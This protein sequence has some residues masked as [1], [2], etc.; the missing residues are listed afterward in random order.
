MLEGPTSDAR[1][2]AVMVIRKAVPTKPIRY[3]V[4]THALRSQADRAQSPRITGHHA[5]SEQAVL[6]AAWAG[7]DLS[8][9]T[10]RHISAGDVETVGAGKVLTDGS[11]TI[12]CIT[13]ISGANAATLIT[14]RRN[15]SYWATAQSAGRR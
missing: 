14:C 6:R 8:S 11:R 15:G 13:W 12:S 1:S 5:R 7:R 4:N 2:V 10:H 3:V 9:L